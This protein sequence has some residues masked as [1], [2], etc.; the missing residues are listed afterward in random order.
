[1]IV[2][3]PCVT[4]HG[5][6]AWKH[7][8][9]DSVNIWQLAD[10]QF[11][12][13]K[14]AKPPKRLKLG[15]LINMDRVKGAVLAAVL[16]SLLKATALVPLLQS[17]HPLLIICLLTTPV[18][19]VNTDDSSGGPK[20]SV[21]E[22]V[23]A[24]FTAWFIAFTAWVAWKRPE[25]SPLIRGTSTCPVAV[26]PDAPTP[27]EKT[28]IRKWEELNTQL[29]GAIVS[30]VAASIQSTLHISHLDDG[31]EAIKS[32]KN[33]FGAQS[34]GDRAEAMARVQR[35]YIDPRAKINVADV[36]KQYNEMSLAVTDIVSTGGARL[37]DS[38]LIWPM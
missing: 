19:G 18:G 13:R 7:T 35:S 33:Q 27:R 36:H 22:G 5:N 2:K 21:F 29:Y 6:L 31:V 12:K 24:T 28:A 14:P 23:N 32:L 11:S 16:G 25:L 34:T 1:M 15:T 10:Y 9:A 26:D 4:G 3:Q 20:C 8:A 38:L 37:D 30:H 17:I